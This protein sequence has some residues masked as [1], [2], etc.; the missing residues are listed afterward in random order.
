MLGVNHDELGLLA[1]LAAA[2][3]L[4]LYLVGGYLRDQLLQRP[5][6][7]YDLVSAGDPTVLA[8]RFA[9][10]V[11]G[12]WFWLDSKRGYS[13]VV[14]RST[15]ELQF[16]FAP[17]RV[18]TLE[19]DLAL[20]DFTINAM[21]LELN[22]DMSSSTFI[23]PL[24][25]QIDLERRCLRMCGANVLADDP[26]RILKGV[27]HCAQFN[28][29]PDV[30]TQEAFKQYA[31]LLE[32]I[33]GERIR[34]EFGQIFATEKPQS[35][36]ELFF[37]C[38]VDNAL[39]IIGDKQQA[40]PSYENV[41]RGL[42]QIYNDESSEYCQL[43]NNQCGNNF[44]FKSALFFSAFLRGYGAESNVIDEVLK[45]LRLERRLANFISFVV[46]VTTEQLLYFAQMRCSQR[47]K[48]LWLQ[49]Q[50]APLP[51]AL[52]ACAVLGNAPV[53]NQLRDNTQELWQTCQQY[54]HNGRI[55]PL[56]TSSQVLQ[57]C[58]QCTGGELGSFFQQLKQAEISGQVNNKQQA[59]CYLKNWRKS[60]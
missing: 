36:L 35:A 34:S 24:G 47:G 3:S 43:L 30:A 48:L 60:H 2:E 22:S 9:K 18:A 37:D 25:G 19:G 33:A 44:T 14:I 15:P 21:A 58:P 49:Q 6:A 51:E 23:D 28:L 7:D 57:H 12:N 59:E 42:A 27:R 54:L 17:F 52:I 8:R 26:L 5:S 38:G 50:N 4:P 1:K 20:R 56:L 11:N 31:P 13:R 53:D 55:T 41:E 29:T 40:V 39:G 16:D 10:Q 45:R 46:H 32:R